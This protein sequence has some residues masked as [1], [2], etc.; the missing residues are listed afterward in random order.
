MRNPRLQK[1][2]INYT[3]NKAL[4]A[5]KKV[6]SELFNQLSTKI[7]PNKRH[8]TDKADLDGAGFDIHN[9][10]GKLPKPKRGFTLPNHNYTEPYNPKNNN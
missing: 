8:K 3:L 1:K 9:M 2:A 4:P 6:G 10:I 5:F 7:R